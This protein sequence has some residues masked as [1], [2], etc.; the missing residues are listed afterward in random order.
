MNMDHNENK[1]TWFSPTIN[2]K[3]LQ[4]YNPHVYPRSSETA[5]KIPT[6]CVSLEQ[7]RQHHFDISLT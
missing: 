4:Q 3:T 5:L 6:K 2:L 7:T 1:K